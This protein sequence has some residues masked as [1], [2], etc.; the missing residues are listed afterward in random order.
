MNGIML[1]KELRQKL[2]QCRIIIITGHD[3][4]VYAQEAIRLSV[5]DYILKPAN[6]EQL[7]QVLTRIRHDLEAAR[8]QDEHLERAS[9]QLVKNFPLMRERFCLEWIEG[10]MTEAELM[11]QLQ[12]L[13]LPVSTPNLLGVIRWPETNANVPLRKENDRQLFMFAIENIISGNAGRL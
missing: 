10:T 12:F 2:P 8:R 4:F 6:A 11:E 3:E 7:G 13:R 5:D 1:M 9:K